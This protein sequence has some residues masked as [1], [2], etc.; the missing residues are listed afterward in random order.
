MSL[1]YAFMVLLKQNEKFKCVCDGKQGFCC[2]DDQNEEGN[3]SMLTSKLH[4]VLNIHVHGF[5]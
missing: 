5:S 3:D 1:K 2:Q 4:L